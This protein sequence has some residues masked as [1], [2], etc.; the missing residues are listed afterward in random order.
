MTLATRSSDIVIVGGGLVGASLA[1]GL[2]K[3]NRR[4]VLLDA[5]DA[6]IRAAH[7]N[8][9]LVWVQNKGY[10]LGAY[11]RWSRRAARAWQ[12]FAQD[13]IDETGVNPMLEQRGGFHLCFDELELS[14][15][16]ARLE[17]IRVS[18]DGDYPYQ[19]IERPALAA[20]LPGIGPE[21]AGASFTEMDGHANPLMLLRALYEACRTRG[22]TVCGGQQVETIQHRLG[23]GFAINTRTA[24]IDA[25]RVVLAAGLGNANLAP[26]VG[27]CA[28][29]RPNRGQILITERVE[30]FLQYPTPYVRQTDN[31]SL[32]LGD[33]MEDV[34]F[35]NGVTTGVIASIAARAIRCFPALAHVKLV[36]S[37][38]ALRVMSPDGFPVY[39]ASATCPGAF[40]VTCHS[41]VTLA[42]LHAAPIADWIASDTT[43]DGIDCFGGDR[44]NMEPVRYEH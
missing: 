42:P 8:F 9:G 21:V 22:V 19:M 36:R 26:Q 17:S 10:G 18:L 39:E 6:G 5:G 28:P 32:Q 14:K 15:R 41:G 30:R 40:V 1:Y 37:W 11:A 27:L 25:E 4:V 33:S 29:V 13:L 38:G 23:G 43:P 7:G 34:G 3:R 12:V 20:L 31:G 24:Q 2:A 16:Q 44:F 35:D